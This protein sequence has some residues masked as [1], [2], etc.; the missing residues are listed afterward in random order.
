MYDNHL[1]ALMSH[2][3]KEVYENYIVRALILGLKGF[4]ITEHWDSYKKI[5]TNLKTLD[6]DSYR[7][8]K[9]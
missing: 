4:T 1:H 5:E 7:T 8:N 9:K 6:V 3:S 2:D